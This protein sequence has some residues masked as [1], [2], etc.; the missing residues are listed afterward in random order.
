[1]SEV[2]EGFKMTELGEIPVEWKIETLDSVLDVRDGTHDSPKYINSGI[3]FLTSKNL[4]NGKLDLTEVNYISEKDHRHF[5]SR[6]FVENGDILFGMIGTVGNPVIV[7]LPFEVSIKNVA[8][9][10]FASSNLNNKFVLEYLNSVFVNEQFRRLSNGGVQKF[11]ALGVIRKLKIIIPTKDEQQKIASIF[12]TVDAQIDETEQS[13]VKTKELKKGLMQQLLTKGIGHTEFKQTELG[14]IPVGWNIETLGSVCS[15]IQDGNYGA[16]YPK[17]DEML[18]EGIP[19]LTSK[20]LGKY[21]GIQ[22]DL[23]N[24]ISEEKHKELKKAHLALN[25][26]LLTNRG[27]SVG[28]IA[29]VT[30]EI[31]H[32]NIGPQLTL[33]RSDSEIIS[34]EFLYQLMKSSIVQSQMQGL[35]SGSAMKFFGIEETK[36][37]KVVLPNIEEQQR[38]A[39]I[40]STVDNQ[41][42]IYEQ[43]K[44]KYEE[45]KKG[46]MQQLL[47]GRIRVKC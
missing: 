11:I 12:S 6:S 3:P 32:G 18:E 43:E 29:Y 22:I 31:A 44:A 10:K 1:M 42:E 46:L 25:D 14:E 7:N 23:I 8:L 19:F 4:R 34:S 2:R 38:I 41:I 40:L 36:K 30:K 35:D 27:A 5:S 28:A 9:L 17:S 13:I 16:K 37:F 33:L 20:V 39:Q 21:G 24:F 15:K 47:T 45:L 26:V